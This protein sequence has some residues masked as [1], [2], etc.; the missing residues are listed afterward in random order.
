MDHKNSIHAFNYNIQKHLNTIQDEI[1]LDP[2]CVVSQHC[3]P[4]I[5]SYVQ[6]TNFIM[7]EHGNEFNKIANTHLKPLYSEHVVIRYMYSLADRIQ[8]VYCYHLIPD[9]DRNFYVFS[10][11]YVGNNTQP[12]SVRLVC[13]VPFTSKSNKSS[14][15][16]KKILY[17]TLYQTLPLPERVYHWGLR[18]IIE[19]APEQEFLMY[20]F[21]LQK[22]TIT[23]A[24]H[25]KNLFIARIP[26]YDTIIRD[27]PTC[28]LG[29]LG[30]LYVLY[31]D[32]PLS[33]VSIKK[34][35]FKIIKYGYDGPKPR[36]ITQLCNSSLETIYQYKYLN[37]DLLGT[38]RHM[39]VYAVT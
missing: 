21:A 6:L 26:I 24:R 37:D 28:K 34:S 30:N 14:R 10:V 27:S 20:V 32:Y 18:K 22:T 9:A 39:Q 11:L 1:I 17:L 12:T 29:I 3:I 4:T 5:S 2:R 19:N 25:V 36:K 35:P 7:L 13:K 23:S 31:K 38:L 16:A 33:S 15:L 8:R